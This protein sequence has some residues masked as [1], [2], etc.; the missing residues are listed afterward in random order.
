VEYR[1]GI[2][3]EKKEVWRQAK[4]LKCK[5]D[6]KPSTKDRWMKISHI[7]EIDGVV[8]AELDEWYA[9]QWDADEYVETNI[10]F[11]TNQAA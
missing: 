1:G 6:V 2:W 8:S 5:Q 9:I 3:Y 4:N 11:P 10:W 7:I